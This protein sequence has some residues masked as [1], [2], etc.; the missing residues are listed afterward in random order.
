MILLFFSV[1]HDI[2][3]SSF[4]LNDDLFKISNWA[5]QWKISFNPKVV[6]QAQEVIFCRKI[7]E[8]T[9][10]IFCFNNSP[11]IQSSSQK[12]LGIHLDK[13]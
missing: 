4:Q 9:H 2:S 5:Y 7:Q 3:L 12:H 13:A 11:V 1:V 6:K 8:V 10:P